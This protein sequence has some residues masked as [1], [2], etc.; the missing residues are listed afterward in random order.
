MYKSRVRQISGTLRK[1]I[2]EILVTLKV[3]KFKLMAKQSCVHFFLAKAKFC[4]NYGLWFRASSNPQ[5]KHPT[6]CTLSCKIFYCLN[7]AQHV[8]GQQFA[9]HQ[10]HF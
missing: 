9:H 5:L 10:E 6:K 7:A 3:G 8:S 4:R 2:D 1:E